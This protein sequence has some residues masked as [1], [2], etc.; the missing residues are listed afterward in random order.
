[1]KRSASEPGLRNKQA[2]KQ[3]TGGKL[4]A[5]K[6]QQNYKYK[7][8]EVLE[9]QSPCRFNVVILKKHPEHPKYPFLSHDHKRFQSRKI[10]I[11]KV[12]RNNARNKLCEV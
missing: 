10:S 8:I 2:S 11:I 3:A 12:A 4:T 1:M 6:A 5:N 7:Q 9:F